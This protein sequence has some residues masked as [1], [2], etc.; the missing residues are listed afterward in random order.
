MIGLA[1]ASQLDPTRLCGGGK[2][3]L[4]KLE[5]PH[6]GGC[7]GFFALLCFVPLFSVCFLGKWD[8]FSNLETLENGRREER[9]KEGKIC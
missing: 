8:F 2:V 6:N 3:G 9:L 4:A 5:P 7:T 1:G